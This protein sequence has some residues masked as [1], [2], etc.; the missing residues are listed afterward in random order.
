MVAWVAGGIGLLHIGYGIGYLAGSGVCAFSRF[1]R[2]FRSVSCLCSCFTFSLSFVL[3]LCSLLSRYW[4]EPIPIY[5][6]VEPECEGNAGFDPRR[7]PHTIRYDTPIPVPGKSLDCLIVRS[8]DDWGTTLYA[9]EAELP[10]RLPQVS[11]YK[12]NSKDGVLSVA[13]GP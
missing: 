8:I 3:I 10:L 11:D 4:G 5:Y 7:D 1:P 2:S 9:T 6:P 12:S 13:T